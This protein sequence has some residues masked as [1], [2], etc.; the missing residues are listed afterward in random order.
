MAQIF[1]L[2]KNTI[3]K[4]AAGEV[5]ERPSSV[6]K[7]LIENAID[8]KATAISVEAK[9]GGISLLRITD[10]GC[11]IEKD[12]VK[13]AFLRHATS[14]IRTIN[15]LETIHSLGF[16]GEALSSISAV[17]Q[18]ELLTKTEDSFTGVRYVIEGGI[19]KEF[20]EIGIPNGTT[21]IIKNIFFNTPARAKFLKT[22]QTEGSY[23]SSLVEHMALCHP[24]ISFSYKINGNIKLQTSG[25]G[26]LTD[27]LYQIYGM[28]IVRNIVEINSTSGGYSLR[29]FIGKPVISRGNRNY[30][31]YY[32]N[33]RYVKDKIVS[34]AIDDGYKAYMMQH[35]FPFTLFFLNLDGH[36]LDV[37]V[38]PAKAEVRFNDERGI[39]DFIR[40]SIEDALSGKSFIP[41]IPLAKSVKSEDEAIQAKAEI[42]P[43][44]PEIKEAAEPFENSLL[45]KVK[46]KAN[47]AFAEKKKE[48]K[49]PLHIIES[50]PIV[51]P[52]YTNTKNNAWDVVP[53]EKED[54]SKT[55]EKVSFVQESFAIDETEK[56]YFKLIGQVFD[57]YWIMEYNKKMYIVDQHAAHEKVNYERFVNR[58]KNKTFSSQQILPPIIVTLSPEEE[59]IVKNHLELFKQYGFEIDSFGGKEYALSSVPTDL[60]GMNEKE[61]FHSL[62]DEFSDSVRIESE[63]DMFLHKIATAACKASVKG[64]DRL[65]FAEAEELL[66]ELF[67][68]EQP[69]HCPH[70]RP[71]MISMTVSEIE[72]MFK[73]IV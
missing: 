32:V 60:Y 36:D 1:E 46:E 43:E 23:I 2:D 10:N 22:P 29:G 5:V 62:V 57:T 69:Y 45:Q 12:Q 21:I 68:A 15:D 25:N 9:D 7:E 30:E 47:T 54:K 34:K 14:K 24:E 27:V 11:G 39:Y 49:E 64:H 18:V 58:F 26:S 44:K 59:N 37:N 41:D 40:G 52:D 31:N 53:Q 4:I 71:T 72:K 42:L 66:K 16:R 13:K 6:A 19:E 73:R 65:S 28:D 48:I 67:N 8:A 51:S 50:S 61:F 3:D 55:R 20:E 35:Q 38:H 17:S 70:G 33:G 56:V 63:P